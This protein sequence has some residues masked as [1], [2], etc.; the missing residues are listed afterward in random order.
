MCLCLCS[1]CRA[2]L[3]STPSTLQ[4]LADEIE[5]HKQTKEVLRRALNSEAIMHMQLTIA[6]KRCTELLQEVRSYSESKA[7]PGLGWDCKN[8]EC[9]A[10]NGDGK[11]RLTHCRCCDAPRP[12]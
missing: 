4:I 1:S 12:T 6:Q 11:E 3:P 7:L 10:F 2:T 5:A 9:G 8:L